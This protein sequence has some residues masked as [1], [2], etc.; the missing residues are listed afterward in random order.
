MK[1]ILLYLKTHGESLDSEIAKAVGI[2]LA[3]VRKHLDVLAAQGEI[4]TYQSTRF[5]NGKKIE[6]IRS[7]LSGIT[8]KAAPG[9]KARVDLKLS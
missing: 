5:E 2:S 9:R 6:G 4:M 8:P 7:R 3:N 1:E